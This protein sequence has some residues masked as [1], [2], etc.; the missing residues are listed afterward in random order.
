MAS[1]PSMSQAVADAV[2]HLPRVAVNDTYKLA[3][4][5]EIIYASDLTWWQR[6]A[7]A[8]ALPGLKV[9]VDGVDRSLPGV[10]AL[11]NTGKR[12]FD[13]DPGA[14]RTQGNSGG[15]ALHLAVHTGAARILLLGFDM[16]G[17]HWHDERVHAPQTFGRW[18]DAMREFAEAVRDRVEI[19]NCSPWSAL[20]CFPRVNLDDVIE[21]Q[22]A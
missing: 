7:A 11:R 14:L 18:I 5:A 3:L 21:R 6:N 17:P 12:G 9:T 16:R 8:L 22:A 19:L 1:G 15:A 2:R 4:D 10:L 20:R 13:A